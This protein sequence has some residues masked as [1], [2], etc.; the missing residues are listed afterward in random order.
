MGIL[1]HLPGW[2]VDWAW[3]PRH[4]GL[5]CFHTRTI[6]LDARLGRRDER[7]VL[8]HELVHAERGPFPRWLRPREERL[9]SSIAARRLIPLDALGE[10]LAWSL[11]AHIVADETS[12][13][14]RCT[15]AS[16]RYEPRSGPIYSIGRNIMAVTDLWH[17]R[18]GA[19]C[20]ECRTKAGA[21]STRHGR[22][23]RWRVTV[24]TIPR[25]RSQSRPTPKRGRRR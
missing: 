23:V 12:T 6:T 25:G 13:S 4:R 1:D 5:T 9:V 22:G 21:P 8:S 7:C 3:A 19:R 14:R 24:G 15:R 10:A 20:P 17:V 11:D 2:R 18:G 16:R